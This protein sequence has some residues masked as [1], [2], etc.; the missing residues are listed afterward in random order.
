MLAGGDYGYCLV[1][2]WPCADKTE[3]HRRERFYIEPNECV[4]LQVPGRTPKEYR[5]GNK[6][7]IRE[8]DKQYR[9]ENKEKISEYN[10][11]YKKVYNSEN[12]EKISEKTKKY[13]TENKEK[14]SEY[15]KE[16][17]LTNKETILEHRKQYQHENKEE[18][19][20]R[21]KLKITCDCGCTLRKT[22][23]I[24]HKKL[25][26]YQTNVTITTITLNRF[27]E[28]LSKL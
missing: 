23:I 21:R 19:S 28:F 27:V 10:K 26:T 22:D 2:K 8:S 13:Q 12:K 7:K 11:E 1:E 4:N 17:Y 9:I 6:E 18:I 24:R 25:K 20:A 5:I 15:K 14:I 3:L 16:H